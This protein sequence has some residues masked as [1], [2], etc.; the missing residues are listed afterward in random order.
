LSLLREAM[1]TAD[2]AAKYLTKS[3]LEKPMDGT[4]LFNWGVFIKPS[5]KDKST[6]L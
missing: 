5:L 4:L 1:E 2:P 6:D 3:L